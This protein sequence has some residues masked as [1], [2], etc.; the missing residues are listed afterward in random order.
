MSK[1][2]HP[3]QAAQREPKFDE[4]LPDSGMME[5]QFPDYNKDQKIKMVH[6]VADAV[7][8]FNYVKFVDS[9]KYKIDLMNGFVIIIDTT[10]NV[11]Y[12]VPVENIRT[13]TFQ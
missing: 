2:K 12:S 10:H 11:K 9:D 13:I 4:C 7:I 1:Y 6:F 5:P 8:N 3:N